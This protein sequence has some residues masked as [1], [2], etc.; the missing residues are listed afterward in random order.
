MVWDRNMFKKKWLEEPV[1]FLLKF[2]APC[3]VVIILR[4]VEFLPA[5]FFYLGE[6]CRI[7]YC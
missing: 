4:F 2:I 5:D 7:K 6:C 1:F 3:Y